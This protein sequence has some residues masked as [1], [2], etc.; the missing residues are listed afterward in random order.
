MPNHSP[1]IQNI[2][3]DYGGVILNI[4]FQRTALA[5]HE[6]GITRFD[7]LYSKAS[8]VHLFDDLEK[9]LT[10][11]AEFHSRVRE[12]SGL[13]LSDE[14]I[15]QAW[16]AI[17][18]DMPE[19]RIRLLEQLKTR[20]RIFLLS[21]T[22]EIH[23][24]LYTKQL[25]NRFGYSGFSDLFEKAYLSFQVKM[26]KP[27]REIFDFVLSDS[28]LDAEKTLFI[29]DSIQHINGAEQVGLQVFHLLPGMEINQLFDPET[30]ELLI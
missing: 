21:N 2:I 7:L 10:G 25:Q 1:G 30:F 5:F 20:Y 16:N 24:R 29:D 27:D 13:E 4:D 9:G 26:K 19:S 3:F 23:Y 8:Q 18:L 15:D 17:I 28:K 6:L 22:N 11:P 12:I 14:K